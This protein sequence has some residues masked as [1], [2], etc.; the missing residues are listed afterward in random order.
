MIAAQIQDLEIKIDR[1]VEKT[2]EFLRKAMI[3]STTASILVIANAIST[4]TIS[5]LLC[6]EIVTNCYGISKEMA[7]KTEG[8]MGMIVGG[9]SALFIGQ[10]IVRN[11][12]MLGVGSAFLEAS[13][14]ARVVLK[15]ACDLIIILDRAFRLDGRSNLVPYEK[16]RAVALNYIAKGRGTSRR[17]QV[18]AAINIVVPLF[19]TKSV[20]SHSSANVSTYSSEIKGIIMQHR[21]EDGV[22]NTSQSNAGDIETRFSSMALIEEDQD[23]EMELAM[24]KE[25]EN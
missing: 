18:H 2:L 11:I 17:S 10:S 21:M 6:N 1:A 14:A 8:L 16:I 13:A 3:A 4:P 12:A 9:N 20:S 15:C 25:A 22:Y 5:R 23:D 19:S 7:A 24:D